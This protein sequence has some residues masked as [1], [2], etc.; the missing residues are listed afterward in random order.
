[1][2]WLPY[3]EFTSTFDDK[4]FDKYHKID[5]TYYA[6]T[7]F[8]LYRIRFVEY[9]SILNF[10]RKL[11]EITIH[12]IIRLNRPNWVSKITYIDNLFN[13]FTKKYSEKLTLKETNEK[14]DNI[15]ISESDKKILLRKNKLESL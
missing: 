15:L 9:D 13:L 3:N 8:R 7:T 12:K 1:M 6:F 4:C 2:K 10:Y 11:D 14:Y 5:R